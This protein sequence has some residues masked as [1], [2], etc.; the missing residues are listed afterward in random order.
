MKEEKEVGEVFD[1]F[2]KIGVAAIKL[3][4]SLKKGDTIHIKG[5]TTDFEQE[6]ESIQIHN[7]AVDKA[8]KGEE[9]GIKMNDKVRKNDVV[10][11][12]E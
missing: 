7:K 10:Y 2:S 3:K 1:Y 4:A 9:V 12:A 11:L 8:K 5:H 6:V